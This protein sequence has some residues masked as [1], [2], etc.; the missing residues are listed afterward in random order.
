VT[1]R[2]QSMDKAGARKANKTKHNKSWKQVV[3]IIYC[4]PLLFTACYKT[5]Q[6]RRRRR[7]NRGMVLSFV[8][9]KCSVLTLQFRIFLHKTD[10]PKRSRVPQPQSQDLKT[11]CLKTT[12][13]GLTRPFK[14]H[15]ISMGRFPQSP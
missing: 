4:W 7:R 2:R 8:S 12:C 11:T 9:A 15:S 13:L 3:D 14:E 1:K 6:S 10:I 5:V